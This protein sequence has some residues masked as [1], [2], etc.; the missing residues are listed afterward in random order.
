MR[1]KRLD[2]RPTDPAEM[3][4]ISCGHHLW[5]SGKRGEWP[6]EV[7]SLALQTVWDAKETIRVP[8]RRSWLESQEKLKIH[9]RKVRYSRVV[10]DGQLAA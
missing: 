1:D 10:T 2:N 4:L 9:M 3:I 6:S 7:V 5:R 8:L